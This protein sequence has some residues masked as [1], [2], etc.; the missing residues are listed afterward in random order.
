MKDSLTYAI[1]GFVAALAVLLLVDPAQSNASKNA[2][3]IPATGDVSRE[4][5]QN[6]VQAAVQTLPSAQ[7]FHVNAGINSGD[8]Q[9]PTFTRAAHEI[10]RIARMA[11]LNPENAPDAVDFYHRCIQ[12]QNLA[13]PVRSLC[14]VALRDLSEELNLAFDASSPRYPDDVRELARFVGSSF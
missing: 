1:L 8:A 6:V 3:V 5:F 4:A 12:R 10:G 14:F 13:T 9:S 7:E 2:R 11:A